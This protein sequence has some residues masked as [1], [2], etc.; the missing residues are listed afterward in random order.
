MTVGK[1]RAVFH[2]IELNHDHVRLHVTEEDLANGCVL[3]RHHS[4][5][6]ERRRIGPQAEDTLP[7]WES[8]IPRGTADSGVHSR[9]ADDV[10]HR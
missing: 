8:I 10:V 2:I 7:H 4:C 5:W 6:I 9:K 3:A 1:D